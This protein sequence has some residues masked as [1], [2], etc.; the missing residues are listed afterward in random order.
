MDP[1][2]AT[3]IP[4]QESLAPV[5]P[6]VYA[7]SAL[8]ERFAHPPAW[9]P[10]LAS[11]RHWLDAP[12]VAAAVLIALVMR[13][14]PSVLLTRR[15]A[16]LRKHAGQISFPGGRI[17]PDD[18]SA[19]QAALREAQEEVG[20]RREHVEL[21]GELPAYLTATGFTVTPVVGL[22]APADLESPDSALRADPDEVDEI[23]EVPLAYLMD[24]S[25]HQRRVI[26][27]PATRL[28]FLAMPWF[29]A[30]RREYF[31]WGATAAM[32]RNLYRFLCA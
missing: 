17:E 22:V 31:I 23:F 21:L 4:N 5:D 10:E 26:E 8:R 13:D 12:P 18:A 25:H 9:Q 11:D 1:R 28:E 14:S 2:T 3:L 19:S 15:G 7:A 27:L 20:L 29:D 32:L 6:R 16:H 30:D 24:P